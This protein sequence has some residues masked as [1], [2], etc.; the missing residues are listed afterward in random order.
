MSAYSELYLD[1]AM[2]TLGG[3]CDYGI[4]ICHVDADRMFTRF[5]VCFR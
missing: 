3:M 5:A 4:N 1:D 2:S